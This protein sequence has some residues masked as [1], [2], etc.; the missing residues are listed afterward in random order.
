MTA[1]SYEMKDMSSREGEP[2]I[3]KIFD[4]DIRRRTSDL[5]LSKGI[6]F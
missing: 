4:L 1:T 3:C 5:I 2:I 6:H